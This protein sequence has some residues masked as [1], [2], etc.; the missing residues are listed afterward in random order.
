M[1]Y[2]VR[3]LAKLSGISS[4]TLRYYDEIDLL[5]P[6]RISSSGYRI[7]GEN[8]VNLLQQILFYK[9]LE[10]PLEK[11][12]SIVTK[13]DFECSSALHEH[14]ENIL[15]RQEELKILLKNVEKTISS[16]E[17]EYNMSNEEKFEGLKKK[18]IQENE[19]KYG[20]E[21]REKYGEDSVNE[22]YKKVSKLSKEQWSEVEALSLKVN[23]TLKEAV[24]TGN[25]AGEKAMEAVKLHKQWLSHFHTYPK[26]AHIGLGQMYVDDERFTKYYED[27]VC[28]NAAVFLRDA[29]LAYYEN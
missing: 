3:D 23:E 10:L 6:C 12:K 24:E 19:E 28:K 11:I 2:T 20:K 15:K 21:I 1:E 14:K 4:R 27:N 26:E 18:M 13:D 16:L 25:P 5:K 29:I 22:S 9:E 8:E 17:G 7:Y